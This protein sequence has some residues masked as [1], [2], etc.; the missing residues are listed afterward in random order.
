MDPAI[1]E[2]ALKK[3]SRDERI[4]KIL[5][6]KDESAVPTGQN[7]LSAI[8]RLRLKVILGN[9]R[10]AN[11]SAIMKSSDVSSEAH[12]SF[13]KDLGIFKTETMMYISVLNEMEYL[14]E[15]FDGAE[16]I[17]WSRLLYYEP[18]STMV[19]E[20]LKP[21]GFKSLLIPCYLDMEHVLLVVRN[22]AL[23]HAMSRV[24]HERGIISA[25]SFPRWYLF[26][27]T[28]YRIWH[29]YLMEFAKVMDKN[30]DK[31]WKPIVSKLQ[32]LTPKEIEERLEGISDF[33]DQSA[34]RVIIHGDCMVP[35][36]MFRYDWANSPSSIKFV[37]F[38]LCAYGIPA[39]DLTY[40][41]YRSMKA[42]SIKENFQEIM[43]CYHDSLTKTLDKFD[44]K[45]SRP[46]LDELNEGMERLSF[47][48]NLLFIV[49]YTPMI[50]SQGDYGD[51]IHKERLFYL[52]NRQESEEDLGPGMREFASKHL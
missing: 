13:I 45:G 8:K 33:S 37:D 23:F 39:F 5:E 38:Q 10:V 3:K 22:L 28:S 15:E 27:K 19:F 50:T 25:D 52:F 7:F 18:Y 43:K 51:D 29:S 40:F 44:Y 31:S 35:N 32:K 6:L 24:L 26:N 30:W 41:L 17:P 36:L 47:L 11:R 34:F 42:T 2:I 4:T 49:N 46:S 14:L 48:G 21:L 1:L 16:E 9:G 20:D 12:S